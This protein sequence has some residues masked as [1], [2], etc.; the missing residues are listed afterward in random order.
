LIATND[1]LPADDEELLR[2]TENHLTACGLT[3]PTFY[4]TR[5][6]LVL[7]PNVEDQVKLQMSC[8]LELA[9][10]FH[11]RKIGVGTWAIP[12]HVRQE[13]QLR[14]LANNLTIICE[15]AAR[16]GLP[17]SVEFETKG[18]LTDY[19]TAMQF[20]VDFDLPIHFTADTYHM[21]TAGSDFREAV[22]A[23]GKR[24]GEV[25]LSGS[26]RGEP[27]SAG[28]ECDYG[29]L[30][31]ALREISYDGPVM[32]QYSVRDLDGIERACRFARNLVRSP[33]NAL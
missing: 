18:A 14:A 28:D 33:G 1:F 13:V 8:V 31:Q 9:L 12:A 29:S 6:D 20:A 26:H 16:Q 10:R 23:L 11:A 7:L 32:L 25:H 30:T 22:A 24:I 17:V 5:D 15:L 2:R 27:G 19:R 4:F 3:V 21:F